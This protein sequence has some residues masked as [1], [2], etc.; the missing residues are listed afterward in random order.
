PSAWGRG[1]S[2][3]REGGGRTSRH[4]PHARPDPVPITPPASRSWSRRKWGRLSEEHRE[5]AVELRQVRLAR[6]I[7]EHLVAIEQ[8]LIAE[9]VVADREGRLPRAVAH[10]QELQRH[11][12]LRRD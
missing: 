11:A 5:T 7:R 1:T 4:R 3:P 12:D 6:G 8:P 2:P 9:V 10:P